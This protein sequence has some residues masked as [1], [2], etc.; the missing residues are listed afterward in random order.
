MTP[1]LSTRLKAATKSIH[2][3]VEHTPFVH[4]MLRGRLSRSAYASL[5]RNLQP[6]Y[7]ALEDGIRSAPATQGLAP[8]AD[9]ALARAEA[10]GRDLLA[11]QVG[12]VADDDRGAG[13]MLTTASSDYVA[14][15]RRLAGEA[16]VLLAAHAYVRYLGDLNGGQVLAR[17][18][19]ESYGGDGREVT[20][21]YD[22]G[23]PGETHRLAAAVREALDALAP[24]ETDARLLID[25]ALHGFERHRD[26]FVELEA[27]HPP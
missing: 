22:F 11:L 27:T 15:L 10:I 24:S 6:I 4:R 1:S 8:L 25:E 3:N 14:H 5:L 2:A 19:R 7:L 26:L 17:L 12:T 9:P 21:F 18:V 20:A 23:G 16:P 13:T